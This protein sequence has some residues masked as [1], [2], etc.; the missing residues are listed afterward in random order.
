MAT[1]TTEIPQ[2]Q[3]AVPAAERAAKVEVN[4]EDLVEILR[5]ANELA[6]LARAL[7]AA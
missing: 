4:A 2:N 7:I 3:M 1:L 5:S 6:R